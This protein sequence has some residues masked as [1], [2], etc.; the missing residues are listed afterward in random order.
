MGLIITRQDI[1][2]GNPSPLPGLPR[3]RYIRPIYNNGDGTM[4]WLEGDIRQSLQAEGKHESRG[5]CCDCRAGCCCEW[6]S[7]NSSHRYSSC[8]R[9][10]RGMRLWAK[11]HIL[12]YA[13]SEYYI[14]SALYKTNQRFNMAECFLL[15]PLATFIFLM[16]NMHFFPESFPASSGKFHSPWKYSIP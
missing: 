9:E 4:P 2:K 10:S 15:R 7:G 3:L 13:P 16:I 11:P 6:S 14:I 5:R 12:Q 8:R 1:R